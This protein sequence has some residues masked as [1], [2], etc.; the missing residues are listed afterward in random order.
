[1]SSLLNSF[2]LNKKLFN[3][4]NNKL[5]LRHF[6]SKKFNKMEHSPKK[7]T[8]NN[9]NDD[10]D[11]EFD[12]ENAR[13]LNEIISLR[14]NKSPILKDRRRLILKNPEKVINIFV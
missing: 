12:E 6:A 9:N 5:I 13:E 14:P 4:F 10:S 3:S 2:K 8:R 7:Y 11:D 1:M